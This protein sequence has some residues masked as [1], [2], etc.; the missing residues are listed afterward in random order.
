M[1]ETVEF[2]LVTPQKLLL[3][4]SVDMVVL[5]GGEGDFGV[6]PGHAPMIST[7]RPGVVNIYDGDS[8]S[9]SIFVSGGFAE[10]NEE[11]C[12]L[13]AGQA[14]DVGDINLD[15]AEARLAAAQDMLDAAE[16]ESPE[17]EKAAAELKI[18]EAMVAATGK[19]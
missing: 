16:T 7:V 19:A 1:T 3:S 10:V 17:A 18:A 8:I 11:R 13:L 4:M 14:L 6:L 2:E 12:T 5:P 9:Q 15:Q